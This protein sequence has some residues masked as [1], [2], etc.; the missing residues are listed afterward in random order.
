M[1]NLAAR[2]CGLVRVAGF[3]SGATGWR[4]GVIGK[5]FWSCQQG[6]EVCPVAHGEL[7]IHLVQRVVDGADGNDQPLRDR[8]AGQPARGH[9]SDFELTGCKVARLK[10]F[11]GG[12]ARAFALCGKRGCPGGGGLSRGPAALGLKCPGSLGGGFC[13]E[14]G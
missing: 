10:Q 1:V 3:G 6:P 7:A 2:H 11:Q 8:L 13:G 4:L 9:R 5:G 14:Q 12:R